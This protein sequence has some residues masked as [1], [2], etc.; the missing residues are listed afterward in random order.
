MGWSGANGHDDAQVVQF[1]AAGRLGHTDDESFNGHYAFDTSFLLLQWSKFCSGLGYCL[2]CAP[3][4][5]NHEKTDASQLAQRM[6]PS[7]YANALTYM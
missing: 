5:T 4:I 1:N 3:A 7:G 6:Q 2:Y